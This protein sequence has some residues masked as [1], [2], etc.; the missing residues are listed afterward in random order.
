MAARRM[1]G[2]KG[3]SLLSKAFREALKL[4]L[5]ELSAWSGWVEGGQELSF[6]P[7]TDSFPHAPTHPLSPHPWLLLT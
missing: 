6:F 1:W 4:R 2:R 5:G 3:T 7:G